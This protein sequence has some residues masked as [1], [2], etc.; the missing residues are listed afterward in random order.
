ML[1]PKK[2]CLPALLRSK[3][4]QDAVFPFRSRVVDESLYPRSLVDGSLQGRAVRQLKRPSIITERGVSLLSGC[5]SCETLRSG[6]GF[7]ELLHSF[8]TDQTLKWCCL[9]GTFFIQVVQEWWPLPPHFT[10]DQVP[11][12]DAS[13]AQ[14]CW[15]LGCFNVAPLFGL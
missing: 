5:D 11:E 14:V 12:C 4:T 9:I 13:C 2:E 3:W 6:R 10:G 8:I 1:D 7:L 15:V